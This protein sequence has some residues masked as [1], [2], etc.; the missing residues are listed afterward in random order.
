MKGHRAYKRKLKKQKKSQ[1]N[2]ITHRDK[3]IA[4][5]SFLGIFLTATFL[6]YRMV[7]FGGPE[8]HFHHQN[9]A[10]EFVDKEE[11]CM[12]NNSYRAE[13]IPSVS[14]NNF[15][16]YGCCE[17]C[18]GQLLKNPEKRYAFDMLTGIKVDKAL[19]IM[20]REIDDNS[21]IYYFKSTENAKAFIQNGGSGS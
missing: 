5:L 9:I 10:Y 16:Y 14:I 20:L 1:K 2:K 18:T 19:A 17:S 4:L 13:N 12:L 6:A 21:K 7:F 3:I 8:S 15:T 11:V